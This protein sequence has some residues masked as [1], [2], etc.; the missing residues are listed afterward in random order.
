VNA[1]ICEEKSAF[2]N[3]R[4]SQNMDRGLWKL[5]LKWKSAKS[6]DSH[7][8]LEKPSAFP[9]FPQAPRAFLLLTYQQKR[10]A[11][12]HLKKADFLS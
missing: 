3:N 11:M 1:P 10:Q 7:F 4:Q 5:T 2:E 8:S 9:Q 6:A 12:I